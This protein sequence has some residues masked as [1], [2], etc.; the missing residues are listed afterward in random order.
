MTCGVPQGSI[1][2][3]LLFLLYVNDMPQAV[4]S[5][6]LLYAD[7]SCLLY[8]HKEIEPIESQLNKDFTNLCDW[9][10]DNKLSIHF[11][12]D[13]T[14]SILFGNKYKI[15]DA[16]KLNISHNNIDIKQHS[17]VCYLGCI[18]DDTLSGESM[19]LKV[20][21]KINAKLKFLYRK[22]K[23]LN[24]ALKRMLCMH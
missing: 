4:E 9:F 23:F 14:K 18:L 24:P 1:I 19:A 20:I 7:D 10:V 3:S 16:K 21:S 17:H 8:Q 22:N 5:K 2:G 6:L 11:G 13:K 15:R 12:E